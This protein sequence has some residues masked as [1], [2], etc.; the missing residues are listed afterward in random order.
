[1]SAPRLAEET[2]KLIVGHLK[3]NI[4][5]AINNVRLERSD[6]EVVL[7]VLDGNSI[8]IYENAKGYRAPAIFV[9][10]DSVEFQKA[11]KQANYID[12]I[13]KMRVSVVVQER[14]QE[15]LTIKAFRYQS[16]LHELLDQTT[17][18]ST[19]NRVKITT[20]VMSCD[21]SPAFSDAR[22]NT[23]ESVFKK[24]VVLSLDVYHY[25]YY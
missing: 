21:F 25:E 19:D 12:A 7:E 6:N 24:E 10:A 5:T 23:T 1:M 11:E 2:T 20:V 18:I 15:K 16:A 17:L 3:N 14:N 13:V 8:F 22:P 4:A 9:I